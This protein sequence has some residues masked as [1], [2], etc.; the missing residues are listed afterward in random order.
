MKLM[1]FIGN[2]LKW[3]SILTVVNRFTRTLRC[4]VNHVAYL[5]GFCIERCVHTL[6]LGNVYGPVAQ[7]DHDRV[8]R[9]YF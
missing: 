7:E 1:A 6:P 8:Q 9:W 2:V 4:F 5:Q 3:P